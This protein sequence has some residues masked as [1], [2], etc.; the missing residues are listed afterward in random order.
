MAKKPGVKMNLTG[1]QVI[2][3]ALKKLD[4]GGYHVQVGIFGDKAGR[5]G[6]MKA[7][8]VTNAEVGYVHEMGSHA[9]GIPRRS[10][11]WDTFAHRGTQLMGELKPAVEN[12]FKKGQVEAYLK[13]A[14]VAAE[15]LVKEAFQTSGWG[16]W[17]PN[18]YR[19]LL[20]KLCGNLQRRRQMAA[21]VLYE[22][23]D[24]AKPL[25]KSGQLWQAIASRT[26]R[27]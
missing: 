25:I 12:L 21:E 6:Q 14:G 8:G 7:A 4:D 16:A 3:S 2:Q 22:G 1:I 10:F 26:V 24:H 27:A 18:S 13:Q 23:A 20:A 19:T 9:H 5:K 15:N 17:P 11:L